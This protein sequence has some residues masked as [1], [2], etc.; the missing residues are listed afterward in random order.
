LSQNCEEIIGGKRVSWTNYGAIV[1]LMLDTPCKKCKNEWRLEHDRYYFSSKKRK[2]V[3]IW[4]KD[5][6]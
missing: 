4:R 6:K 5:K 1:L 2:V 3:D